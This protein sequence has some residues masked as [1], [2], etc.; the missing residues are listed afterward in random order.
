LTRVL[1]APWA[2]TSSGAYSVAG[3]LPIGLL[4]PIRPPITAPSSPA[5]GGDEPL[6][7]P[8]PHAAS[9]TSAIHPAILDLVIILVPSL[10]A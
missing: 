6:A 2:P 4:L 9:A 3:A 5:R 10:G 8:P 1:V 7:P